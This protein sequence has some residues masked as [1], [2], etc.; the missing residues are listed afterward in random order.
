MQ[1]YKRSSFRKLGMPALS[2]LRAT[3]TLEILD[4][5]DTE[6]MNNPN[7]SIPLDFYLRYHFLKNKQLGSTDRDAIVDYVFTLMRWKG[8]LNAIC[9]RPM[10]WRNRLKAFQS[11]DFDE[12]KDNKRIP[13]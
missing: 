9:K 7:R 11:P 12:L 8:Y 5:Y 1:A 6:H 3:Q 4:G 13:E 10:N 2:N